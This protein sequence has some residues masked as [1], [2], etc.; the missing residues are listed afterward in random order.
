MTCP[1]FAQGPAS[2][3]VEGLFCRADSALCA[4]SE[5][6]ESRMKEVAPVEELFTAALSVRPE[7]G[8]IARAQFKGPGR[9][10]HFAGG[11]FRPKE[12]RR[13]N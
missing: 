5:R 4:L 12:H 6:P 3:A 10:R 9:Q 2:A 11:F 8:L 7:F 13:V 1:S